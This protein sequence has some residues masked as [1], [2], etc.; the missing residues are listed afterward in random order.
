ARR[1]APEGCAGGGQHMTETKLARPRTRRA[2]R[3]GI[4][5]GACV[6]RARKHRL[7]RPRGF[8]Y[9]CDGRELFAVL[10]LKADGWHVIIR[11][12]EIGV[13]ADRESAL[14]LVTTT[15]PTKKK[16]F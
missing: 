13:C 3:L 2:R 5:A 1:H 4:V 16:E 12:Q 15:S 8:Q 11:N 7:P 6:V 10:E 9:V 14:R